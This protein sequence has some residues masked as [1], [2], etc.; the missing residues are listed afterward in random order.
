MAA[1]VCGTGPAAAAVPGA[2][3]PAVT[4][5]V[6]AQPRTLT[7][8]LDGAPYQIDLP[9]RWNGTLLLSSHG[10]ELPPAPPHIGDDIAPIGTAGWLLAHGYALAA[11]AYSQDGW[12]VRQAFGDQIA[13]LDFFTRTIGRP[14]QT[15]ADGISMGGLITAGLIQLY[16]NRFAGGL[17]ICGVTAGAEALFNEG[18]D[19]LFVLKTLLDPSGLQLPPVTDP[20]RQLAAVRTSI[21]AALATPAGRARLALAAAVL[22]LPQAPGGPQAS[23]RQQAVW[24]QGL[25][26]QID[27]AGLADITQRAAGIPVTNAD[28]S[29]AVQLRGSTD[30]REVTALYTDA[31]LS[32][33]GDLARL[34]AAPRVTASPAATAYLYRYIQPDGHLDRPV[35]TLHDT[36]DPEAVVENEQA[37]ARQVR[38]A[39]SAPMLRQLYVNRTGHCTYTPAEA[40]TALL[41]LQRRIAAGYWPAA[42]PAVLNRETASLGPALNMLAS[43]P[44]GPAFLAYQPAPYLR[45]AAGMSN[46]IAAS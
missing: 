30:A 34:A 36:G 23:V 17:A 21:T 1:I 32:L 31:G 20:T 40:I 42:D 43:A 44:A 6:P 14:R 10:Y 41:Q 22:D 16:P 25:W 2:P 5:P 39:G 19:G 37:Y 26:A 35:L 13:L 3:S 27:S 4:A 45:P 18:L 15:I 28:V 8:V 24:M 12:A 38:A 46:S 7:G 9:A 11:S 29:Y 33:P